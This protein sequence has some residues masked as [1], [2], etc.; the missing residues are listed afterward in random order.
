MFVFASTE[1]TRLFPTGIFS[2]LTAEELTPPE[3]RTFFWEIG[4]NPVQETVTSAA[5]MSE[6]QSARLEEFPVVT[7]REP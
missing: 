5:V 3:I 2:I 1:T 7:A 4:E 6:T